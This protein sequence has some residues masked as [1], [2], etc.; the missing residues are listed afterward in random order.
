MTSRLIWREIMTITFMVI[1]SGDGRSRALGAIT[2][3]L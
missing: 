3:H 2:S 1:P